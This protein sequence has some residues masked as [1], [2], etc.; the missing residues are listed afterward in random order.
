MY[1]R[2]RFVDKLQ[3]RKFSA[4]CENNGIILCDKLEGAFIVLRCKEDIENLKKLLD[5]LEIREMI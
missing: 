1:P 5:S 4:I 2:I 3:P